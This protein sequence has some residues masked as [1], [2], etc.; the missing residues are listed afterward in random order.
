MVQWIL[1]DLESGTVLN[2]DC[3]ELVLTYVTYASLLLWALR[4][5]LMDSPAIPLGGALAFHLFVLRGCQG[6]TMWI[7]FELFTPEGYCLK[8]WTFGGQVLALATDPSTS[9]SRLSTS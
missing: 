4:D 2:L 7:S 9:L 1:L 5:F 8:A 3:P 6:L